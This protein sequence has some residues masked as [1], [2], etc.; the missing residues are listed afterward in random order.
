MQNTGDDFSN[1]K[2]L[3][4]P[5]GLV[6]ADSKK[7]LDYLFSNGN[8]LLTIYTGELAVPKDTQ[9]LLA[10]FSGGE[11]IISRTHKYDGRVLAFLDLL[12]QNNRVIK[13]PFYSDLGLIS[14]IYQTYEERLG[15]H[16]LLPH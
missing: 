5:S 11:I 16:I 9:N 10:Y 4:V 3:S 12:R 2:E 6:N 1:V 8:R 7:I 15:N 14:N 13:E